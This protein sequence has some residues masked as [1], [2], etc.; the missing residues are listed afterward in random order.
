MLFLFCILTSPLDGLVPKR[1]SSYTTAMPYKCRNMGYRNRSCFTHRCLCIIA[2]TCTS[3]YKF[4]K[5]PSWI[6]TNFEIYC[7]KICV[8]I[9][10]YFLISKKKKTSQK[11]EFKKFKNLSFQFI[12]WRGTGGNDPCNWKE[13]MMLQMDCFICIMQLIIA[14]VHPYI[15]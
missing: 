6:T 11:L 3:I 5:K 7:F 1:F 9:Y 15:W 10:I 2:N 13:S 8:S 4:K 12:K 14:V